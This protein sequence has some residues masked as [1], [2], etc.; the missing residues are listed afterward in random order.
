MSTVDFR[1]CPGISQRHGEKD[2][3]FSF[4]IPIVSSEYREEA[5]ALEKFAV[6]ILQVNS[7]APAPTSHCSWSHSA[8]PVLVTAVLTQASFF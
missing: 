2:T 1:W 6:V 8:N 3:I 7:A 4:Q 5:H